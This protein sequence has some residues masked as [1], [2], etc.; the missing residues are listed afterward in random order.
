M[1][2]IPERVLGEKMGMG[3]R[4][5]RPESHRLNSEHQHMI[6][7]ERSYICT[8]EPAEVW[9]EVIFDSLCSSWKR[10]PP[11]EEDEQHDVGE[12]SGEVN[13]L[14]TRERQRIRSVRIR[15]NVFEPDVKGALT[16]PVDLIPFQMQK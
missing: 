7:N 13:H 1:L 8:T 10:H 9:L 3:Q 2:L 5:L 16:L 14:Q 11:D 12:R 4:L 15:A 6:M